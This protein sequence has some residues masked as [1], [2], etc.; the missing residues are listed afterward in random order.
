MIVSI[1]KLSRTLFFPLLLAVA[2]LFAQQVGAA[3]ALHHALENFAQQQEDK[4]TPHSDTCEQCA[5]YAQ[6]GSAL[7]VGAYDFTPLLVSDETISDFT[8][9]FRFLSVP[10]AAARGPPAQFKIID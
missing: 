1:M 10:A 6:L 2:L 9:A 8:A 7:S 5:A 3:H 4:Q